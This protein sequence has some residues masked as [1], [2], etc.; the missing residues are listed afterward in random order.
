MQKKV[1]L[2]WNYDDRVLSGVAL[3]T[4]IVATVRVSVRL[5]SVCYRAVARGMVA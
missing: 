4:A 5:L 1:C 3:V 2:A